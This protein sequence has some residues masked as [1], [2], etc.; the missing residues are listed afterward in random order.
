MRT[1]ERPRLEE[2]VEI[3]AGKVKE[4]YSHWRTAYSCKRG[5]GVQVVF[6]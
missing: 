4:L 6:H 3:T 5:R 1:W 2:V